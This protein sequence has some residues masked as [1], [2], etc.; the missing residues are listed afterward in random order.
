M[1]GHRLPFSQLAMLFWYNTIS[2][3]SVQTASRNSGNL[4]VYRRMVSLP[5]RLGAKDTPQG[6][7]LPALL[8][9]LSILGVG[10]GTGWEGSTW[11]FLSQSFFSLLRGQTITRDLTL[12]EE[13]QG[14]SSFRDICYP[15]K[16]R[17]VF[18]VDG[19]QC[20]SLA[21]GSERAGVEKHPGK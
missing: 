3:R 7:P 9:P 15:Q 5:P 21:L 1:F 19:S 2:W 20:V 17:K 13:S 18:E 6:L 14:R 4:T 12:P 11:S 8:C 16:K 10:M